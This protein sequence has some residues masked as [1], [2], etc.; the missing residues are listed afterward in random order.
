MTGEK[1]RHLL[2]FPAT[3]E[4]RSAA[5]ENVQGSPQVFDSMNAFIRSTTRERTFSRQAAKLFGQRSRLSS[6]AADAR[7]ESASSSG[8]TSS[9]S[10]SNVDAAY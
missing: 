7:T 6:S 4:E 2:N 1:K 10:R 9:P 5:A 3:A 8:C